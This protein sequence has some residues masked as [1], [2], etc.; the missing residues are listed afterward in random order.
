M[1]ET[2]GSVPLVHID[3]VCDA[4][5]FCMEKPSMRGRFLCA[6]ANPA[7]LEIATYFRENYP[8]YTLQDYWFMGKEKGGIGLDSSK[9]TTMGFQYKCDMKKI[10]DDGVKCGRRL[11]ALSLG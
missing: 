10:L 7:M 9:L 2:L 4:H 8:E 5:S 1:Q 3:D 11:G 6:A